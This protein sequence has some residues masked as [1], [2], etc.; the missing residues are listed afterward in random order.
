TANI[1]RSPMCCAWRNADSAGNL[2]DD[3]RLQT[4]EK[5]APRASSIIRR[6]SLTE[7]PMSRWFTL[8]HHHAPYDS[9][10]S[11]RANGDELH[12]RNL[13]YIFRGANYETRRLFAQSET[14]QNRGI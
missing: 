8:T 5:S 12:R 6:L 1:P 2:R 10:G 4:V 9:M 3:G 7:L 11:G 13:L 14:G